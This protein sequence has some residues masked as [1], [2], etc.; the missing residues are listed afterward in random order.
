MYK[1]HSQKSVYRALQA[2]DKRYKSGGS[3]NIHSWPREEFF[4]NVAALK[5]LTYRYFENN[6]DSGSF[7][8]WLKTHDVTEETISKLEREYRLNHAG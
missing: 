5:M 4:T 3:I 6:H 1:N 8:L 2:I 7:E